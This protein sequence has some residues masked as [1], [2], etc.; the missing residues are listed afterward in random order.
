MPN[1]NRRNMNIRHTDE[2]VVIQVK[3]IPGSSRSEISE[4]LDNGQ[5]KIKL[6]SP[7]IEGKANKECIKLLSKELKLPKSSIE[8]VSGDKSRNKIV[9]LKATKDIVEKNIFSLFN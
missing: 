4:I 8:I 1:D 6:N 5:L 7:P 3:V 2:G 9:F